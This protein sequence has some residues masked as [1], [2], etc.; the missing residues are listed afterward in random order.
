MDKE[1]KAGNPVII[2]IRANGRGAG[3]YVVVHNKDSKGRYIV[4]DP[5]WGANLF[6]DSTRENI[7]TLYGS[8]TSIDQMIIYHGTGGTFK[9]VKGGS[10]DPKEQCEDSGGRWSKTKEKCRCEKT[11]YVE[12]GGE[13]V[14]E[15]EAIN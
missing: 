14:K 11:G 4:H 12:K 9:N 2:F 8:S 3:H 5:Y 13:C 10:S 7:S 1:I 6:L 15:G